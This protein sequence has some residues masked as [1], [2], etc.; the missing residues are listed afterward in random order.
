MRCVS[1]HFIDFVVTHM[2]YCQS[3]LYDIELQV[4][5]DYFSLML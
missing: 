4:S 3:I 5:N 2:I 1:L